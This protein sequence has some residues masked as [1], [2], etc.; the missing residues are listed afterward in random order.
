MPSTTGPVA[1]DVL[2]SGVELAVE[3]SEGVVDGSA[4]EHTDAFALALEELEHLSL[5]D[6]TQTFDEEDA[7]EDGNEEFF[8]DDDGKDC[9]DTSDGE[10]ACVAHK[11]L[12]WIGI[13]PQK[14]DEG[15][16]HGADE[17]H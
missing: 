8:V 6:D 9:Y 1:E 13:V 12:R 14:S 5:D 17:D 3:T 16:H 15:S 4:L 2:G 7:T 11:H 10:R